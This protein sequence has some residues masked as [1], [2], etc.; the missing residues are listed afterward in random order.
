VERAEALPPK[1][2]KPLERPPKYEVRTEPRSRRDSVQEAKVVECGF[3]NLR[4]NSEEVAQFWYR[5]TWCK[6]TYRMVVLRKNISV[7]RGER[8][9]FD[10]VR[11]LFYLIN[12]SRAPAPEVVF[13]SNR[14]SN[15]ENLI[16]QLKN[17][18]W[19]TRMPVDSL[20]SNWAYMVMASLA[21]TLKVWFALLLPEQGRWAAAY[22]R[23]KLAVLRMEFKAFLNAF[24][25]VPAQV[26]RTGRRIVF[27]LLSWNPWQHVFLRAVD[28]LHG[29]LRY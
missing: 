11:Y 29:S 12:D 4:L 2:W 14:R 6:K 10:E 18:V 23:E 20:L 19:A 15:Q 24:L 9:L 8:R 16:D 25:W 1:A 27:R 5:P 13:E 17:G 3:E 22:A 28:Q 21:W 26:V 7:E